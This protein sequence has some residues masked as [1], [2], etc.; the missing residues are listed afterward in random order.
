MIEEISSLGGLID[1]ID[2]PIKPVEQGISLF[3]HYLGNQA[4]TESLSFA[5]K[6][7]PILN[8]LRV[9]NPSLERSRGI[10]KFPKL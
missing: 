2:D 3:R 8:I 4:L 6:I 5:M 7:Q 1:T 10:T 9:F